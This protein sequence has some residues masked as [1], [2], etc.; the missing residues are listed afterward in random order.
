MSHW[1]QTPCLPTR[2]Q[3]SRKAVRIVVKPGAAASLRN[4]P[5][6]RAVIDALDRRSD[7]VIAELIELI[8]FV[9]IETLDQEG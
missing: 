3:S 9:D 1:W 5:A 7:E 4:V 8:R 6:P 2:A